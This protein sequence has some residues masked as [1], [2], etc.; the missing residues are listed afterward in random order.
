MAWVDDD[1]TS[2]SEDGADVKLTD[3]PVDATGRLLGSAAHDII[4]IRTP[5]EGNV[6]ERTEHQPDLSADGRHLAFTL[7][8][9]TNPVEGTVLINDL[10]TARFAV[11]AAAG[12]DSTFPA[13][14]GN[15]SIVAF[16]AAVTCTPGGTTCGDAPTQVMVADRDADGDGLL[17]DLVAVGEPIERALLSY[18]EQSQ[19]VET[20]VPSLGL[21]VAP[22]IT[23]DGRYVSF[24]SNA[25]DLHDGSD[26]DRCARE[27]GDTRC[28]QVVVRDRLAPLVADQDDSARLVSAALLLETESATGSAVCGFTDAEDAL[29]C[30]GNRHSGLHLVGQLP[31]IVNPALSASARRIAFE[32]DASISWPRTGTGRPMCSCG[33]SR[34]R[35]R[36]PR[37]RS[38]TVQCSRTRTAGAKR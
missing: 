37:E 23:P 38:P 9:T 15:G 32:S 19:S 1:L 22:D 14:S 11:V 21:N 20:L 12:Q 10:D 27:Q 8:F 17:N 31:E 18:E 28:L 4:D 30:G 33:R 35:S 5:G 16:T 25:P 26:I 7:A 2:T 24:L 29:R 13:I 34:R 6:P 36:A 3:V